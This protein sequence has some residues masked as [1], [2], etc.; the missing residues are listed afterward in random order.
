MSKV[1]K[2]E[3]GKPLKGSCGDEV[4]YKLA[5][6]DIVLHF[7]ENPT[8][9]NKEL[10]VWAQSKG[11]DSSDIA[12]IIKHL[13]YARVF[14]KSVRKEYTDHV[15]IS[16]KCNRAA[17]DNMLPLIRQ[18]QVMGSVGSSRSI[19]IEDYDGKNRFGFDGDGP[20][21]IES[22]ELD[23][24]LV[25]SNSEGN[26]EKAK[27]TKR[28]GSPGS[29]KYYY[30]AVELRRQRDAAVDKQFKRNKQAHDA[31]VSDVE[32]MTDPVKIEAAIKQAVTAMQSAKTRAQSMRLNGRLVALRAQ[33][34]ESKKK[35]VKKETSGT[36]P[37]GE[38][39]LAEANIIFSIKQTLPQDISTLTTGNATSLIKQAV[40]MPL[41]T[42]RRNQDI[43]EQQKGMAYK[44]KN[45]KALDR[46]EVM[47]DIYTAA[48]DIKEFKD[49]TPKEWG[50]EIIERI[51]KMKKSL[52]KEKV[53]SPQ[54]S[55]MEDFMERGKSGLA[56]VIFPG[57]LT[58]AANLSGVGGSIKH[59]AGLSSVGG[60]T[61]SK[62]PYTSHTERMALAK[63]A[64]ERM[65]A[66]KPE[67]EGKYADTPEVD[68]KGREKG[69]KPAGAVGSTGVS[70]EGSQAH[71]N[72]GRETVIVNPTDLGA[73]RPE[74]AA[75]YGGVKK[76]PRKS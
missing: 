5:K 57:E 28:T 37:Q 24:E 21:N 11:H 51:R 54:K 32:K 73:G 3:N 30:D 26:M 58:K 72:F 70:G 20:D 38:N 48:V 22:I 47:G 18:L 13:N 55:K 49:T 74:S 40:K 12:D 33:L 43:V 60:K 76:V 45:Y 67:N 2:D 14:K 62:I 31:G 61:K 39:T 42:L 23:G 15:E 44:K 46:L 6:R 7:R 64:A 4:A 71:E 41:K 1:I 9:S 27:Y 52:I 66:P 50:E 35:T 56:L 53:A 16:I 65:M 17:A 69:Q 8:I 63:M 29:Y 75:K 36:L 10:L 68:R 59:P 34:Q 25:K 19:T